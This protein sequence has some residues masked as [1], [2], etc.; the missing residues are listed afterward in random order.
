VEGVKVAGE[1]IEGGLFWSGL[2]FERVVRLP[3][4]WDG[5]GLGRAGDEFG[6][7][8]PSRFGAEVK[9]RGLRGD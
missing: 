4:L 6:E 3:V 7:L 9:S 1:A 2:V 5:L 8:I